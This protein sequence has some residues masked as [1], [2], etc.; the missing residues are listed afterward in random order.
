MK[1]IKMA[2]NNYH[3]VNYY[4]ADQVAT[5]LGADLRIINYGGIHC[6]Y[7]ASPNRYLN[8]VFQQPSPLKA[9][10]P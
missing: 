9:L 8:H 7:N 1:E 10:L 6:K 3:H 2:N 4:W 5:T